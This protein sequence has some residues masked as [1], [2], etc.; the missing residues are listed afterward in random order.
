MARVGTA[1]GNAANPLEKLILL[2]STPGTW[3]QRKGHSHGSSKVRLSWGS[4]PH[5]GSHVP[6]GYLSGGCRVWVWRERILRS[7]IFPYSLTTRN[8][9]ARKHAQVP[10]PGLAALTVGERVQLLPTPEREVVLRVQPEGS[11]ECS[12]LGWEGR[13]SN[14]QQFTLL[15]SGFLFFTFSNMEWEPNRGAIW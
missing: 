11:A 9:S 13:N 1:C 14:D 2:T 15:S 6:W 10:F 7:A 3:E 8:W 5:A 4:G 12:R